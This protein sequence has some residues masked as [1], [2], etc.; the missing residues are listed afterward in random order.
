MRQSIGDIIVI[1]R[2][3]KNKLPFLTYWDTATSAIEYMA[4]ILQHTI[5]RLP[6]FIQTPD[7]KP[8]TEHTINISDQSPMNVPTI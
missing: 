7:H 2:K 5:L 1:M 8:T 6:P 3:L 4:N